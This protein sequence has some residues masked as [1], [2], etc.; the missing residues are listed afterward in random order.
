M[1]IDLLAVMRV[2]SKTIP[3]F[4]HV[5]GI[6]EVVYYWKMVI[7][8]RRVVDKVRWLFTIMVAKSK[9]VHLIASSSP[10]MYLFRILCSVWLSYCCVFCCVLY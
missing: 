1:S 10:Y 2:L 4:K 9:G 7:S 8:S 6:V 5:S 3:L